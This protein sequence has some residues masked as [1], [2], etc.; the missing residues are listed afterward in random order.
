MEIYLK[1]IP[2]EYQKTVIESA[3]SMMREFGYAALLMDMGTG[4]SLC[5]LSVAVK[6]AYQQIIILCPKTL[7]NSWRSQIE[8]HTTLS[9]RVMVWDPQKVKTEKWKRGFFVWRKLNPRIAVLN[10]EAFQTKNPLLS[11]LISSLE[12]DNLK[13]FLILDESTK[14]KNADANRTKKIVVDTPETWNRAIL[15]GTPVTNSPLD[16]F[17]QYEFLKKGFWGFVGTLKNSFYRFRYRYAIM[18]D[19]RVSRDKTVKKVVG[20]RRLDDLKKRIEHCTI[21]LR[22]EDCID[23][24]EKMEIDIPIEMCAEQRRFYDE[25]AKR[26]VAELDDNTLSVT[27]AIQKFTRLRQICGGFF[28]ENEEKRHE[29]ILPNGKLDFLMDD[30]EDTNEK[31][32]IVANYH[33]EINMIYEALI[34]EYDKCSTAVYTGAQ[35]TETRAENLNQFEHNDEVRFLLINPQTGAF[36]LNLQFCRIMYLYSY[37]LSVEQHVQLKD[38]IYRIGQKNNCLYKYLYYVNSIDERIKKLLSDRIELAK[39]FTSKDDIKTFLLGA[40]K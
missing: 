25:F 35:N 15:T 17:T 4:K 18:I 39:I 24:P 1:T 8:A 5:S 11:K 30:I 37:T 26:L 22:K 38:R 19:E 33:E 34:A 21:Q 32:I 29:R 3:S 2:Y 9:N 36:G 6:N 20:Y 7:V 27:S 40:G 23:L 31:I 13:T 28:V 14:I 10:I 16:F 12:K